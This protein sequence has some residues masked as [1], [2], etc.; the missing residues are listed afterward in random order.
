MAIE[1]CNFEYLKIE[2][3]YVSLFASGLS[4]NELSQEDFKQIKD[5]SYMIGTNYFLLYYT[6]H[7]L[8]FSDP[9]TL[10]FNTEIISKNGKQCLILTHKD[11]FELDMHSPFKMKVDYWFNR[12]HYKLYSNYTAIWALQLLKRFFPDKEILLFGFDFY[13]PETAYG[14]DKI[15]RVKCY[16]YKTD[17]DLKD[18]DTDRALRN[19]ERFEKDLIDLKDNDESFINNV[20]NCNLKSRTLVFKR[21]DWR[22]ILS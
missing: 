16:D 3:K 20:W 19:L 15:L 22:E 7:L 13:V 4:I 17:Y 10:D 9:K 8:F 21:K 6:P 18:R 14:K 2:Q 1:D 11:A 5:K 12:H